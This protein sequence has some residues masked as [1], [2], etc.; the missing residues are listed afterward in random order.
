[1]HGGESGR[2]Y[3]FW[4]AD[5]MANP[6]HTQAEI[7]MQG[8]MRYTWHE[9]ND[10]ITMQLIPSVINDYFGHMGGVGEINLLFELFNPNQT[11]WYRNWK[12]K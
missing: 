7:N 2:S 12:K 4:C 5:E 3:N 1:M 6:G 8:G 11:G 9:C 10:M